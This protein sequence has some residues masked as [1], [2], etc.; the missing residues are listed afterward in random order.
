M[1]S[2]PRSYWRWIPIGRNPTAWYAD[3]EGY[4]K[5]L[6]QKGVVKLPSPPLDLPEWVK[7][8]RR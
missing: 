8:S 3:P 2:G 1:P 5:L 6:E 7:D 4:R